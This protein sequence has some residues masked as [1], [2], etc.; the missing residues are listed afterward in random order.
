MKW[1]VLVIVVYIAGYTFINIAYRKPAGSAHEPYAESRERSLRTVQSTMNG[2]TRVA[3]SLR[4]EN[5]DAPAEPASVTVLPLPEPLDRQL[6]ADLPLIMPGRPA[7]HPAALRLT[8]PAQARADEPLH[9]RLEFAVD[10]TAVGFG[11]V[12]AYFK[13]NHLYV[14][15]Q[16]QRHVA[17]GTQ[18][19]PAASPLT[20]ELPAGTLTAGAW[21]AS[22]F[23]ASQAFTWSFHV[24]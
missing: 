6:P 12:L 7:L 3:C 19:T 5:T 4:P 8:A 22:A 18:P 21:Q 13:D 1:I 20:L 15:I 14:F 24:E 10:S 11:E 17:P 16:D 2:W 9:V 23:T